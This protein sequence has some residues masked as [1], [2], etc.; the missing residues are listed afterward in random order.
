MSEQAPPL[1][2]PE[3]RT[4]SPLPVR[5]YQRWFFITAGT[6]AG[7]AVLIASNVGGIRSWLASQLYPHPQISAVAVLPLEN[8]SGDPEQAYFADGMTD[9]LITD[10]AKMGSVRVISR[11]TV[12]RY[13]PGKTSRTLDAN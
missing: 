9:A 13:R 6:L 2:S 1:P 11:T 12:M 7:L 3:S 5:N 4:E 10:L 8:L